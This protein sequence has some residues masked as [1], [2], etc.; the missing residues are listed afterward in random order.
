MYAIA[1]VRYRKP[2][3]EIVKVTEAH[4]AYLK[5][6]ADQGLILASG[7]QDPRN[8]GV[9]LFRVPDDNGA[10]ILDQIRDNDP[11]TVHGLAQYELIPWVPMTGKEAMER[12]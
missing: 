6:F 12:L 8:G 9:I 11:F 10:A 1:I 2:L 7:P 4:R 5:T 3:E